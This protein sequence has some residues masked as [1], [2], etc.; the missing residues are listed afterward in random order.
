MRRY[1]AGVLVEE[2]H[3]RI[4]FGIASLVGERQG[5]DP[6]F[7]L[8]RNAQ[9][10]PAGGQHRDMLRSRAPGEPQ[11]RALLHDLLAVVQHQQQLAGAQPGHQGLFR[12]EQGVLDLQ[13]ARDGRDDQRAVMHC[14]KVDEMDPV[15]EGIVE[16]PGK[17]DGQRGFP[18]P[19]RT[20]QRHHPGR[21]IAQLGSDAL[22]IRISAD[23]G[24]WVIGQAS[25]MR[26]VDDQSRKRVR[27]SGRVDLEDAN[28]T[29]HI[30]QDMATEVAQ[31]MTGRPA[32]RFGHRRTAKNLTAVAGSHQSVQLVQH[33]SEIV[34]AGRLGFTGVGCHA[35]REAQVGREALPLLGL[36]SP[37][38]LD[39]GGHRL[40]RRFENRADT[41][42]R[43]IE[44]RSAVTLDGIAQDAL[45]P[46]DG[47]AHDRGMPLPEPGAAF[48]IGKEEGERWLA[49]HRTRH[50]V[51]GRTPDWDRG[52]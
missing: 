5:L 21:A 28:R 35:D 20:E 30:A 16:L 1:L 11:A 29:R 32:D 14:R 2:L 50:S 46:R 23:Q 19:A 9:R 42:A 31:R 38:P 43:G 47:R 13:G 12:A 39:R 10:R 37:L 15:G 36:E 6:F 8:G 25:G 27:Q 3:R 41:I 4:P 48:D 34:A 51:Q 52:W 45:V 24:G 7:A 18:D 40:T 26:A 22:Q 49:C 33:R 44:D 17:R